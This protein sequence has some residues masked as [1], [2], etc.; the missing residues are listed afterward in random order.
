MVLPVK[1]TTGYS[2]DVQDA[3]DDLTQLRAYATEIAESIGVINT[4]IQTL[5]EDVKISK[6]AIKEVDKE[7]GNAAQASERDERSGG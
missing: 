2:Q 6:A 1:W 4:T 5:S 3:L 7:L